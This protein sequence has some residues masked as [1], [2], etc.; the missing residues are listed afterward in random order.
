M[1]STLALNSPEPMPA[2]PFNANVAAGATY[3]PLQNWQ[4]RF[5]PQKALLEVMVNAAAVGVVQNLT[6]GP[7][8][9]VQAESVVSAGGT[10]G[11]I[12]ARLNNEPIVDMV[13]SGQ[14]IVHAIRNTTGGAIQVQGVAIL[15]YK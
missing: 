12:P 5:P 13:E 1:K 15:T 14:E 2:F 10:A 6:T 9:I 8:S 7:E 3:Y 11:V 4:Y